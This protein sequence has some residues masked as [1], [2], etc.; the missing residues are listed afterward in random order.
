MDIPDIMGG[1]S[2]DIR[3]IWRISWSG[4]SVLY[5]VK[6]G[7]VF[8]NQLAFVDRLAHWISETLFGKMGIC[9]KLVFSTSRCSIA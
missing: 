7:K 2:R 5:I 4:V 6:M 1:V 9:N 3:R 8:R